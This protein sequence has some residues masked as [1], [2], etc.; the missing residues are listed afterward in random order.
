[1][2]VREAANVRKGPSIDTPRQLVLYPGDRVVATSHGGQWL[3][4]SRPAQNEGSPPMLGY[5]YASLLEDAPGSA[6]GSAKAVADRPKVSPW[7]LDDVPGLEFTPAVEMRLGWD[8]NIFFKGDSGWEGLIRPSLEA[9]HEAERTTL[10][11]RA[12]LES[13]SYPGNTQY[14][15]INQ[16]YSLDLSYALSPRTSAFASTGAM[17][18]S[19][20]ES[21]LEE[22]G[23][24]VDKQDRRVLDASAGFRICPDDSNALVLEGEAQTIRHEDDESDRSEL[25][26]TLRWEHGLSRRLVTAS[27]I[28]TKQYD[29]REGTQRVHQ[30]TLGLTY[31]L[32]DTLT[33]S[34]QAGG[35]VSD[36]SFDVAG[37]EVDE[38]SVDAVASASATWMTERNT[39][40]AS[41]ALEPVGS[42]QGENMRRML[43]RVSVSRQLTDRLT[44]RAT[45]MANSAETKGYVSLK[46][47]RAA[48]FDT[49][50]RY[51]ISEQVDVSL[52]YAYTSTKDRETD[53]KDERNQAFIGFSW[54]FLQ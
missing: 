29:Y 19:S 27:E 3:V 21:A 33:V 18:D 17:F 44:L 43:A 50:L 42:T 9:V 40:K 46:R 37:G 20:F 25:G 4:V 54:T 11:L 2:V 1:M 13:Y 35:A 28:R 39:L 16:Q 52:G 26:L 47:N 6:G 51:R 45:A 14:D 5:V 34:G 30:A 10:A 31:R 12:D 48:K 24:V 23:S 49:E 15:H 32:S 22:S 41:L 7:K 8:D 53:Q 38:R 36:S